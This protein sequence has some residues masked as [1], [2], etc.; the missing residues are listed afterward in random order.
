MDRFALLL[1]K[2]NV[3]IT[4]GYLPGARS[5][6]LAAPGIARIVV[7]QW[8]HPFERN[9]TI[10]IQLG[11][12]ELG[13]RCPSYLDLVGA[14]WT[15]WQATRARR[16]AASYLIPD[17]LLEQAYRENWYHWQLAECAEVTP[18]FVELRARS[19]PF[20]CRRP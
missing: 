4:S 5:E 18:A 8:L 7:S 20:F 9:E 12:L 10:A 3:E 14:W 2:W 11:H 15:S 6:M 19:A 16:W 13:H 17:E 1:K